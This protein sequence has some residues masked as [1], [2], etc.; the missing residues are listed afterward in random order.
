MP[1]WQ[2]SKDNSTL[3]TTDDLG[4]GLD[5]IGLDWSVCPPAGLTRTTIVD[6]LGGFQ[7]P[8]EEFLPVDWPASPAAFWI[9]L[10]VSPSR[11]SVSV[12]IDPVDA[13]AHL[14]PR[15]VTQGNE[16]IDH[17]D[18]PGF[19]HLLTL[20]VLADRPGGNQRREIA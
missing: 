3:G 7:C 6:V 1:P 16:S 17:L 11:L 14:L 13:L 9:R 15:D 8:A 10:R 12:P 19:L 18:L 20:L 4:L 2:K 5:Q